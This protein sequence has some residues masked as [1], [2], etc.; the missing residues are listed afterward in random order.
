MRKAACVLAVLVLAGCGGS[1]RLSRAELVRRTGKIC[2]EQS[3]KIAQ[4]PRGPA[5]ALNAAGYL[6][7]V[8]SVV[9]QGVKDFHALRPPADLESGY[10]KLLA[11]LDRNADILRTLRAA[12]AAKDR[13]DYEL[14]LGNLHRSRMRIDALERRLGL[15][16]CSSAG[17]SG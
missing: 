2:A 1:S 14:G 8:L 7:A 12:A 13:R 17:P 5:T 10:R 11:E 3:R 6:G 15:T 9:E 16:G 4:V